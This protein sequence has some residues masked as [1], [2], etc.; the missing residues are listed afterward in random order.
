MKTKGIPREILHLLGCALLILNGLA[1]FLPGMPY[2][3]ASGVT[4]SFSLA[5]VLWMFA[6]PIFAFLLVETFR[7]TQDFKRLAAGVL[8]FAA[9]F[10]IPFDLVQCCQCHTK[11]VQ[12]FLLEISKD[13]SSQIFLPLS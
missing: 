8:L 5:N 7:N 10:E 11:S 13:I 2:Q 9:V 12:Y 4:V 3:L 6:F 1:V